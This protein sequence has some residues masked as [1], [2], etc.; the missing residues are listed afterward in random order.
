MLWYSSEATSV[1]PVG[2]SC[3]LAAQV[4]VQL[5]DP[6]VSRPVAHEG[7]PEEQEAPGSAVVGGAIGRVNQW[8]RFL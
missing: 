5:L 7:D 6:G 3:V 2:S 8:I 1:S 4:P